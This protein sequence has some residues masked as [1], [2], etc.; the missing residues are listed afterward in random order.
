M[1][2]V[3]FSTMILTTTQLMIQE[4]LSVL[5]TYHSG[6]DVSEAQHIHISGAS[7]GTFNQNMWGLFYIDADGNI[8][9]GTDIS[10]G[11]L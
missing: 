10:T 3:A 5:C 11:S 6:E 1:S 2:I 8:A 9:S 4:L 7:V